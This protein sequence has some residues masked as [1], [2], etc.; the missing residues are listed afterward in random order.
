MAIA[1]SDV[2]G[3]GNWGRWGAEDQRGAANLLTDSMVLEALRSCSTGKVYSLGLPLQRDGVP[4]VSFRGSPQRLTMINHSDEAM[5]EAFGGKP[6]TGANEDVLIMATHSVTHMDALCHIYD[7]GAVYNGFPKDEMAA[8]GGAAHCGIE[9]AGAIAARGVLIDVAASHGTNSLEPG[10]VI[11]PDDLENALST[12]QV[13]LRSGDVVLI[14]T[15]WVESFLTSGE[16]T[17]VQPGIGLDAA[18]FLADKDV[19]AV[20]ADNTA[21]E[22]QPFDR[23]EFLGVHVELLVKR[24]IY[25]LEHLGLAELSADRCYEFLFCVGPLKITGGTASPVNPIA[26][27]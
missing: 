3:V 23:G 19:V 14:R 5:F 18:K 7:D 8:Y 4:L 15:G 9:N 22:A 21:V 27:G 6:G 20:C 26:I 13:D 2:E 10:Y 11:T 12:Q 24:G 17:L 25:L 16:M 1:D